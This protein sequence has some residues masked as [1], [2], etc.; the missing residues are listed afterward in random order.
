MSKRSKPIYV[1]AQVRMNEGNAA[2]GILLEILLLYVGL[3]GYLFCNTTALDMNIHPLI[4]L[5]V[6]AIAFGLMILMVWYKRVFFSVLGGIGALSLLGWKISFPLYQSLWRALEVCYNYTIHLLATQPD[7]SDYKD[8]MTMDIADI[9]KTPTVLQ[10]YFYTAIILLALIAAVFFAL[11]LFRRIPPIVSFLVPA[12]LLVPFFFYGIVPH[13]IA[14]SVFLSAVVGCYGQSLTRSLSKG[15]EKK[16]KKEK[17][18]KAPK[19]RKKYTTK[20]RLAFASQNGNFGVVVTAVMLIITIATASFIYSRPIVQMEQ[21]RASIDMLAEDAMN[22][23]FAETYEKNLNVA[24][25][26]EEGEALSLELPRWRRLKVAKITTTTEL[27]VYLRYRPT[28]AITEEGWLA[29]DGSYEELLRSGL[30]N[31]FYEYTQ[32]YEYLKLTAPSGD[33]K[34][35]KLDAV[36]A[37][38]EGY[39]NDTVTV[40]PQYRASNF[41][42]I[43][44]GAADTA[45]QGKYTQLEQVADTALMYHKQPSDRT[46]SFDIVSPL[47]TGNDFLSKFQANQDAYLSMRRKN[48]NRDFYLMNEWIYSRMVMN[49]YTVLPTELRNMVQKD[50][51]NITKNYDDKIE[52]VQAIERYL[53]ENY[54]YS[55]ERRKLSREDGTP[56]DAFD[57]IRYFLYQNEK[58][59]GYCTLFASSMTAMLR[60]L[61]IPARVV[62]GYYVEPQMV[63]LDQYSA[64]IYDHNHH[65]WVEV[66]FDGIGWVSFEPTAGFGVERNY[67]LLDLSDQG[68][69]PQYNEGDVEVEYVEPDEGIILYNVIPEPIETDLPEEEETRPV[70]LPDL[71]EESG[72]WLL[73]IEIL[74][75]MM[76]LGAIVGGLWYLHHSRLKKIRT[77][78]ATEGVREAYTIILR[79]M[80]M[81]GFK[82]FEGELLESFAQRVDNLSISPLPMKPIVPALQKALY[83]TEEIGEEERD[84]VAAFTK[85]LDRKLFGRVEPI[86]WLWITFNLDKKPRYKAMIWKFK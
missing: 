82:F 50:A 70:L 69:E 30:D 40:R 57:Q 64:Q 77:L 2:G 78:P 27:P 37:E 17:G 72:W 71:S 46:Y 1:P 63:D 12:A 16:P 25:Y 10:R 59:D 32:Y 15:R 56:A 75:L 45:P 23:V 43:P 20:E 34:T 60:S 28:M 84:A 33:P 31:G 6:A 47:L 35:A 44:N 61:G 55:A 51:V 52:K 24:G 39:V 54:T 11:A 41:L 80:Q 86:R 29:A 18:K 4:I 21:V 49:Y 65:A 19:I 7:Y 67:Y 66:Y 5:P 85:A 81:R 36:D 83:G 68:E 48:A 8:Y 62:S 76:L 42:G 38:F 53:R 3:A 73:A 58:K 22:L 9:L 79:L 14:F 13:Y 26:M 74:L